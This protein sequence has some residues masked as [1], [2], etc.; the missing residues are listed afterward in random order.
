MISRMKRF[1]KKKIV[2][3]KMCVLTFLQRLPEIFLILRNVQRDII[4]HLHLYSCKVPV[5]LNVFFV[6]LEFSRQIFEKCP[7]IKFH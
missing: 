5:T 4:K 7:G 3:H 2:E 6:K 1:K